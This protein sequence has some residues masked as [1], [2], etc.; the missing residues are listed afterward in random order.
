MTAYPAGPYLLTIDYVWNGLSH[1][2]AIN[3]DTIGDPETGT[4]P[5]EVSIRNKN[6]SNVLLED[7]A[8]AFWDVMRVFFHLQTLA[9]TYSLWKMNAFNDDRLF[10]S[11]GVLTNPNG[12]NIT[13]PNTAASQAIYTFRSGKGN[14]LKLVLLEGVWGDNEKV[15]M[16]SDTTAG[17]LALRTYMLSDAS[18]VMARDRSFAVAPINSSYGQNEKVWQR[19]FRS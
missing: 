19:R 18:I 2:L 3:C 8:D 5:A 9:S 6:A 11:G 15:P 1:E 13:E 16:A 4:H 7:A 10:I 12:A 14:I 17:V